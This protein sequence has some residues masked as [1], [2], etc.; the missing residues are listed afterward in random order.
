ML[1][2][3]TVVSELE[4]AFS[5]FKPVE[6]DL[7]AQLKAIDAFEKKAVDSAEQ[8]ATKVGEELKKLE[9][10]LGDI[11]GARSFD[12]LTVRPD[13]LV[14]SLT[15]QVDDVAAAEP[16]I[17]EALIKQ[18]KRGRWD[19]P[20]RR[21]IS[22]TLTRAGVHGEVPQARRHLETPCNPVLLRVL[23]LR[24]LLSRLRWV[25]RYTG[26]RY[27]GRGSR[28]RQRRADNG[29]AAVPAALVRSVLGPPWRTRMQLLAYL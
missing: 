20:V 28:P 25:S 19:V 22:S 9:A 6:Y 18:L 21:V 1:K 24:G 10:T 26:R 17:D 3:Q 2:N 14:A 23:S 4:K 12:Q 29:L 15:L 8:T 5:S 11:E 7:S 16:K 13:A 27:E